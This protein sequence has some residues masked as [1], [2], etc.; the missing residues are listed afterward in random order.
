MHSQES[1]RR[2]QQNIDCITRQP[3]KSR[4]ERGT[5]LRKF[6]YPSLLAGSMLL[7]GFTALATLGQ[8]LSKQQSQILSQQSGFLSNYSELQPDP[9]NPDLLI[10]WKNKGLSRLP[11]R[12]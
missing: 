7:V 3:Q 5:S 4:I 11:L 8:D 2:I 10:Y 6:I 12:S 9:K 1:S